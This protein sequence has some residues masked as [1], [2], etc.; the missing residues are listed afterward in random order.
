MNEPRDVYNKVKA[1]SPLAE[2]FQDHQVDTYK[3]SD[4]TDETHDIRIKFQALFTKVRKL[5]VS[6]GVT[7]KDF[8]SFL[9]D[10]PGYGRISLLSKEMISKLF[11]APDLIDV[12]NTVR[13]HCSW[14]NHSLLDVIIDVY[15]KDNRE[16]RKAC[17]EYH[18]KLQKYC[19]NPVRLHPFK[20]GYGRGGEKDKELIMKVDKEWE[21]I[22]INQMQE[23]VHNIARI[24][25]VS[26]ETLRL[27]SV[28][29]GCVQLTLWVP[30]YI[31]DAAFP[32]TPEQEA[33]MKE[34]GVIDLQCGNYHFPCQVCSAQYTVC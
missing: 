32:L 19:K 18:A 20:D 3:E 4:L 2:H 5:L 17:K 8:V 21:A 11:N 9:K 27:C 29:K 28:E 16:I 23:I 6:R 30:S 22:R 34:M 31:P 33:A 26:R 13:D 15:C 12:F 1:D 14:F 25:K 10:L 24:L 7:V